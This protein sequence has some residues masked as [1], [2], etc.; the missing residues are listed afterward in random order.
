[1]A[2]VRSW[3]LVCLLVAGGLGIARAQES[4]PAAGVTL[5]FH[6][7]VEVSGGQILL[8]DVASIQ[9]EDEALRGRLA[10]VPL[11][12]APR[13]GQDYLLRA[14]ITRLAL[15]RERE[16]L[17][18]TDQDVAFTGAKTVRVR[19]SGQTVEPEQLLESLRGWLTDRAVETYGAERVELE[20]LM[21]PPPARVPKGA[22]TAES[23]IRVLP[24]RPQPVF[25]LPV[26]VSVDG[27]VFQTVTMAL[28][29]RVYRTVAVAARALHR[30]EELTETDV[31]MREMDL[32]TTGGYAAF[33][34]A[35]DVLGR[36]AT[37][38]IRLGE[39]LT[40]QNVEPVP[41]VERG[42]PVTIFLESPRIRI[43]TM[44][45]AQ[46]AGR[47]GDVIRVKNVRSGQMIRCIVTG[48]RVVRV[49]LPLGRT[50]MA[51]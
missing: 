24:T 32:T 3:G 36:R 42:D 9:T 16:A 7:Q 21:T 40:A 17:G 33:G 5:R 10:K 14:D 11:G 43:M 6:E 15:R 23:Q 48:E 45:E 1:M 49:D 50:A 35:A 28:K 37:R 29:L 27:S 31:E 18:I 51:R 41:L 47:E 34:A 8:S 30:H 19:T 2:R 22:W 20:Y 38:M 12:A 25:S 26:N 4:T 39:P 44:G 46:Q 13:V